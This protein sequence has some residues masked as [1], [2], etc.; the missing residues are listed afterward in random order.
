MSVINNKIL[1]D[2]VVQIN[3]LSDIRAGPC[4]DISIIGK[5]ISCV[6][7][8]PIFSVVCQNP[9]EHTE[10][11]MAILRN[12]ALEADNERLRRLFGLQRD[13]ITR[14]YV[15]SRFFCILC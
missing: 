1:I 6:R 11:L 15:P 14:F 4:S 10:D 13:G 9:P 8:V 7:E 2:L 5:I 3:N 12:C